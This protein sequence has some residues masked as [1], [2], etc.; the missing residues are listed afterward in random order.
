LN[1]LF[2]QD[3]PPVVYQFIHYLRIVG[4]LCGFGITCVNV[5]AAYISPAYANHSFW[6]KNGQFS[7]VDIEK[8]AINN[9][10]NDITTRA[11][12]VDAGGQVAAIAGNNINILAGQSATSL[13]TASF[14]S[15]KSLF[16]K[17]STEIRSDSASTRTLSSEIGGATVLLSAGNNILVK[18]S[19]VISDNQTTLVA[20]TSKTDGNP[21]SSGNPATGGNITIEANTNTNTSSNFKETKSSGFSLTDSGFFIGSTQNSTDRKAQGSTATGS[22]VASLNGNVTIVATGTY[23]QT[24]SDVLT[25]Q[26][27]ITI[28][29]KN[30]IIQTKRPHRGHQQPGDV[31]HPNRARHEPS[32]QANQRR[33]HA[34]PGSGH[35]GASH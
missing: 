15:G 19:N 25:P 5:Q 24:G 9:V 31:G 7:D 30:V 11:S 33:A 6:K 14:A 8:F 26:G 2:V 16:G 32:G 4:M 28:Q 20:G 29:A 3:N 10:V 23:Q 34:S 21:A 18:G 27:D 13:S 22:T 17:G 35:W 1:Q 12:T